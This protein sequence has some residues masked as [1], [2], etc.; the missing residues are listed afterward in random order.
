LTAGAGGVLATL[1]PVK[2]SAGEIFSTFY[3]S[4]AGVSAAE[5]L[6]RSQVMIIHSHEVGSPAQRAAIGDWASY[7]VTGGVH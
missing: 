5:A 6:Q 7:Q 4:L 2:D 1:W 3:R